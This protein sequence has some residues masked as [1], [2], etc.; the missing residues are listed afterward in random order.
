[1]PEYDREKP[2]IFKE[3]QYF[4]VVIISDTR[5]VNFRAIERYI[6]VAVREKGKKLVITGGVGLTKRYNYLLERYF[7][8]VLESKSAC[9]KEV[10]MRL[11]NLGLEDTLTF[12]GFNRF[13]PRTPNLEILAKWDSEDYPALVRR[14]IGRGEVILFTSDCSPVW[15]TPSIQKHGFKEMWKRIIY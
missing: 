5:K 3:L 14:K 4:D 12:K 10:K 15:G 9:W 13:K 11:K 1:M 2:I 6:D 8:G 7:G